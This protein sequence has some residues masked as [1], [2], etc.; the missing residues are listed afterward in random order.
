M[1]VYIFFFLAVILASCSDNYQGYSSDI[2]KKKIT[3]K[4]VKEEFQTL[5]DSAFLNGSILIY[6]LE[7]DTY[8][9]NNYIWCDEGKLPA[10]TFKIPNSII[11][12]E[13]GIV[14]N[15][16]SILKWDGENRWNQNW[17]QDLKFKDA[18]RYSCVPCYQEIARQIGVERMIQHLVFLDYGNINVDSNNIDMFW[19]EGESKITQFEQ[20]DFLK[21]FYEHQLPITVHTQSTMNKMM[22]ITDTIN[23]KLSGKTGWSV[24]NGINNVWF[25]GFIETN[26]KTYFFATNLEPKGDFDI[27]Q[28]VR[29]RKELTESA[30]KIVTN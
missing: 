12:L 10:S 7:K 18:L 22:V 1:K 26:N 21:R 19:L 13:L 27:N 24:F 6:D 11:A 23:Y 28:L 4:I 25:V 29:K 3:N 17:N 9:S 14:N 20:I 5:I 16:S 30:I 8:Y 15:D 2:S